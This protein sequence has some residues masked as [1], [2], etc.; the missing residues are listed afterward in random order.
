[1][2]NDPSAYLEVGAYIEDQDFI[3]EKSMDGFEL[4]MI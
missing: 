2:Q 1:M 4:P 3:E